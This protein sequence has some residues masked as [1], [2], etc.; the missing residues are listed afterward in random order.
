MDAGVADKKSIRKN[1]PPKRHSF[2]WVISLADDLTLILLTFLPSLSW[3]LSAD[4]TPPPQGSLAPSSHN[5]ELQEI[6]VERIH[7]APNPPSH[8][9]TFKV[10]HQ[11]RLWVVDQLKP[12][13]NR[14]QSTITSGQAPLQKRF[15]IVIYEDLDGKEGYETS[16]VFIEWTEKHPDLLKPVIFVDEG[17]V[18]LGTASGLSLIHDIDQDGKA[19]LKRDLISEAEYVNGHSPLSVTAITKGP[20]GWIFFTSLDHDLG[21]LELSPSD[22]GYPT[23]A[24][25]KCRPDGSSIQKTATGLN[26]PKDLIF[27]AYG[28]LF[29]SDEGKEITRK[30]RCIYITQGADYG[31]RKPNHQEPKASPLLTYRS[32]ALPQGMDIQRPFQ[33]IGILPPSRSKQS[34]SQR[35]IACGSGKSSKEIY[36]FS[37]ILKNG[38][39]QLTNLNQW[40]LNISPNQMTMSP[41]GKL[42][43]T[44]L[45]NAQDSN[46]S[47]GIYKIILPSERHLPSSIHTASILGADLSKKTTARLIHLFQH[48]DQRVRTKAQTALVKRGS[49]TLRALTQAAKDPYNAMS[50]LHAIWAVGQLSEYDREIAGRNDIQAW[51]NDLMKDPSSEIRAQA[52]VLAGRVGDVSIHRMLV[53]RM[54]DPSERVRQM[55]VTAAGKLRLN[56]VLETMI[57]FIAAPDNHHPL[58]QQAAFVAMADACSEDALSTLAVHHDPKVRRS[59][60]LALRRQKSNQTARFMNDDSSDIMIEAAQ[61]IH[62]TPI[63]N[64]LPQLARL[65]ENRKVW[66]KKFESETE[67]TES[68]SACAIEMLYYVY[69][70]N[71][72]LGKAE[73]LKTIV[74]A[75]GDQALPGSIRRMCLQ[76]VRSWIGDKTSEDSPDE[77]HNR[78]AS[79]TV[80]K[81]AAEEWLTSSD[82]RQ[83][84]IMLGYLEAFG[85]NEFKPAVASLFRTFNA[86]PETRASALKLLF[87]WEPE[88]I[89]PYLNEALISN[90]AFLRKE[91]V[92]VQAKLDPTDAVA[93]WTEKLEFGEVKEK[94]EALIQLGSLPD[95]RVDAVLLHWLT[96]AL[97]NDLPQSLSRYLEQAAAQ[98]TPPAVRKSLKQWQKAN[99]VTPENQ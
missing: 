73:H 34:S 72:I 36:A 59:G 21:H 68:L 11:Q 90:S 55:A 28:N 58:L 30:P 86:R 69:H 19:D 14:V 94:Q 16:R 52:A 6:H 79:K 35:F 77:T 29:T 10:D 66:V 22:S 18:Y 61:S 23:S 49:T 50:R 71:F 67:D 74:S 32:E 31:Y 91:A 65:H 39:F 81:Q 98:R 63:Q 89:A 84:E 51:L 76:W 80:L 70:A 96:R 2:L 27:D 99:Q 48:P 33:H 26:H 37:L 13:I 46:Q 43:M 9:L 7:F 20:F 41:D 40:N 64:A 92:L 4:T 62:N 25:F 8:P 24:I 17:L 85:W 88:H 78:S 54:K 47:P 42:Y 56:G 44:Q 87:H 15:R 53:E 45:I 95:R 5:Y 57:E 83:Q 97:Q 38:S 82:T 12:A 60:N 75:A 3:H 93:R 1:I